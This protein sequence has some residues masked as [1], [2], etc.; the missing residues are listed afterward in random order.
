MV[1][2]RPLDFDAMICAMWNAA[3]SGTTAISND[4]M[5]LFALIATVSFAN[6]RF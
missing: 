4:A 1:R 2:D 3:F 6:A 5:A